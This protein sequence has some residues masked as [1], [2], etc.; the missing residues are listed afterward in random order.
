MWSEALASDAPHAVPHPPVWGGGAPVSPLA[1]PPAVAPAAKVKLQQAKAIAGQIVQSK[2]LTALVVFLFTMLLLIVL[3]PPMA[4]ETLSEEQKA[5]GKKAGRSWKKIMV[6]SLLVLAITL[7]V[8]VAVSYI[9]AAGGSQNA[10][11]SA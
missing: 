3:N 6:W 10:E 1:S 11:S 4:Q 7:I 8:P 9:P 2:V 5:A